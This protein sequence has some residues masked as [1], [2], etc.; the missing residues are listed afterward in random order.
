MLAMQATL[1]SDTDFYDLLELL[2]LTLMDAAEKEKDAE[3]L[4]VPV[5]ILHSLLHYAIAINSTAPVAPTRETLVWSLHPYVLA[6]LSGSYF[7]LFQRYATTLVAWTRREVLGMISLCQSGTSQRFSPCYY[8]W[9]S[10]GCNDVAGFEW[11]A[12]QSS[13]AAS[14]SAGQDAETALLKRLDDLMWRWRMLLIFGGD[15]VQTVVTGVLNAETSWAD[16]EIVKAGKYHRLSGELL[17]VYSGK[18]SAD[19][20][21]GAS[22]DS[23]SEESTASS[24]VVDD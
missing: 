22:C 4:P 1:H 12:L 10:G 24:V 6:S 3:S 9:A 13:P 23:D 11:K 19:G 17:S 2:A 7:Q 14:H 20:L 8:K 16:E 18:H 21:T 5:L 15:E